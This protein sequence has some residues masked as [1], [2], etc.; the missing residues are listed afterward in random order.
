MAVQRSDAA[1]V[2]V[3]RHHPELNGLQRR[4]TGDP[5][6]KGER[7]DLMP[8][9]EFIFRARQHTLEAGGGLS[10]V[11]NDNRPEGHMPEV[12]APGEVGQARRTQ[13]QT[14]Q[15]FD[16]VVG[17]GFERLDLSVVE[18]GTLG[19]QMSDEAACRVRHRGAP[20]RFPG[21]SGC[22][23]RAPAS[24]RPGRAPRGCAD[25]PRVRSRRAGRNSDC[26]LQ[27]GCRR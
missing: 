26:H 6:D 3:M 13:G 17:V 2:P 10:E 24:V 7:Q 8:F 15:L 5:G 12:F 4:F 18:L 14:G 21:R 11:V 19:K 23:R 25:R 20:L 16:H 9:G 1:R 22:A 27:N